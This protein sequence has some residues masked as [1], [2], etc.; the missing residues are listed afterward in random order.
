MQHWG[1]EYSN[2]YPS[3]GI[4]SSDAGRTSIRADGIIWSDIA[5]AVSS[6]SRIKKNIEDIPDNIALEMVR[7]IP[8]RYYE[9]IDNTF[10]KRQGKT[11]G[12]IAQ[13]VKAVLPM[14][15]NQ[16]SKFIPD[17]MKMLSIEN[18]HIIDWIEDV[19]NSNNKI[20][21]LKYNELGNVNNI[22]YKFYVT[23]ISNNLSLEKNI[24]GNEDNTFTFN[25]KWNYIFCYGKKLMIF[26]P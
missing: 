22:E 4:S 14:A 10:I 25:K 9:Y 20:F 6:D 24:I 7:N 11:I 12:F 21:K 13:E 16:E 19:D 1:V 26:I 15:V 2:G 8:C 18:E 17:I 5:V 23:D 3:G